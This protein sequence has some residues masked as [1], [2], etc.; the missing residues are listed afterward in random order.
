MVSSVSLDTVPFRPRPQPSRG[1]CGRRGSSSSRKQRTQKKHKE[2]SCML[3]D[4]DHDIEEEMCS[5]LCTVHCKERRKCQCCSQC[6]DAATTWPIGV[7]LELQLGYSQKWSPLGAKSSLT[8]SHSS[9]FLQLALWNT[10][11]LCLMPNVWGGKKHRI[12]RTVYHNASK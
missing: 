2:T 4:H 10:L 5:R 9:Q 1:A 8:V 7:S 12:Q 3:H 11:Q 6:Y